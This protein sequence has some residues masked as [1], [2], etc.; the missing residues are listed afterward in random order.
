MTMRPRDTKLVMQQT[1]CCSPQSLGS[2]PATPNHLGGF[3]SKSNK[4]ESHKS[5]LISS[6]QGLLYSLVLSSIHSLNPTQGYTLITQSHKEVGETSTMATKPLGT[7][8]NE[9]NKAWNSSPPRRGLRGINSRSQQNQRYVTIRTRNFR[10]LQPG[11]SG[12]SNQL[13]ISAMCTKSGT[14]GFQIWNFRICPGSKVKM[15]T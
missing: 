14:S 7:T 4:C 5:R 10:I 2:Q 11:T 9:Q 15:C 6:A 12:F 3:T 13:A 1:C 8:S